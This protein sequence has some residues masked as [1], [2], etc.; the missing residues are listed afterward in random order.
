MANKI[1]VTGAAG[2]IGSEFAV[3]S[4]DRGDELVV[5]DALTYAGNMEN[6]AEIEGKYKFIH[7]DI[8]DSNLVYKLLKD[9]D[10]DYLVNFAA[11]SHVDNSIEAPEI[12]IKT[13]V[14]GTHSLLEAT[15]K[16]Y[17]E[18]SGDKQANF[19]Y[20]QV[21]TDEVFGDLELDGDDRFSEDTPYNPS[22]PYSASKAAAD[23]LVRA[24]HRTYS[25][26]CIITN[27]S[28]NYGQ[29]QFT[30]KLIPHM[31]TCALE[32]KN[33]PIYGD[34][35]NVRDWIHVE[36]HAHGVYIALT[37]GQIGES[38]CFGGNAEMANIDLVNAI[39]EILDELQPLGAKS[40]K[41]QLS[42]VKDRA[43]HDRRYAINSS[44]A[45]KELGFKRKYDLNEGLKQTVRWYLSK[46]E[47]RH[48]GHYISR[49]IGH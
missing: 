25:L 5:L 48:E 12:F 34:G 28:N 45:E 14:N 21:S 46:M 7:G 33:L 39:C 17:G 8:C 6:L 47:K 9:N 31:I 36:D 42:F 19:R 10:I 44:K 18:L 4:I 2:F 26:P 13:N 27:C 37:K 3:Q 15:R 38:Y 20:L 41:E 43:G 23:H 16:Y 32:G 49:R 30:E 11:E 35:K 24:Y 22:S 1:L 29:R 40:Y